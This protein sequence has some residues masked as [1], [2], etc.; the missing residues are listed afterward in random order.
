MQVGEQAADHAP[1][2]FARSRW[3]RLLGRAYFDSA[4]GG[5]SMPTLEGVFLVASFCSA[6]GRKSAAAQLEK[7]SRGHSTPS[8]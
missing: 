6:F 2:R 1:R 7:P 4:D 5:D 8:A 3:N